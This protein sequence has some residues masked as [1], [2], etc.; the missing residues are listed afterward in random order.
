MLDFSKDI[1]FLVANPLVPLVENCAALINKEKLV[2]FGVGALC[3]Q[4]S[5]Q[6]IA[7]ILGKDNEIIVDYEVEILPETVQVA[8]CSKP[9]QTIGSKKVHKP[10]TLVPPAATVFA[11]PEA[12]SMCSELQIYAGDF[13][14]TGNKPLEGMTWS[15]VDITPAPTD[16]D[17]IRGKMETR[18]GTFSGDFFTLRYIEMYPDS[19]VSAKLEFTNFL[20][21]PGSTTFSFSTLNSLTHPV[22]VKLFNPAMQNATVFYPKD[23]FNVSAYVKSSTCATNKLKIV[24]AA[25]R[26]YLEVILLSDSSVVHAQDLNF[27]TTVTDYEVNSS[28]AVPALTLAAGTPYKVLVSAEFDEATNYT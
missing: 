6:Q 11:P 9:V 28:F 22:V 12:V 23:V 3:F 1:V 16:G 14:N 5:P 4:K 19:T 10:M 24:P 26:L 20:G 21:V 27:S 18:M 13:Q 25:V 17:I 15:V 2:N 8:T 7:V